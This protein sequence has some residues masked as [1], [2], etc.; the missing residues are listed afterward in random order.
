MRTIES[1]A[2]TGRARRRS[3][4]MPEGRN[5]FT[6]VRLTIRSRDRAL[7]F[8]AMMATRWSLEHRRPDP[9]DRRTP[10]VGI[11]YFRKR[12]ASGG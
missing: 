6:I 9:F 11:A 2:L 4:D 1:E 5:P 3:S 10:P 12:I 7:D 8:D